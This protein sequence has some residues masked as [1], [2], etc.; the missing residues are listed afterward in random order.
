MDPSGLT[1]LPSVYGM[2]R[3]ALA[4]AVATGAEPRQRFVYLAGDR[5]ALI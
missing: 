5:P 2:K 3:E 4:A 1:F